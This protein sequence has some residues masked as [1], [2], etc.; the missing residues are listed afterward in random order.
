MT[1]SKLF[2]TGDHDTWVT[3]TD[4]CI[5]VKSSKV[6]QF[7]WHPHFKYCLA[8]YL[9]LKIESC[10][11]KEKFL[12][13]S[14]VYWSNLG[15]VPSHNNYQVQSPEWSWHHT[16]SC[17]VHSV[18]VAPEILS[19]WSA[20]S[21][22]FVHVRKKKNQCWEESVMAFELQNGTKYILINTRK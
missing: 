15:F 8:S 1:V 5:Q 9:E 21:D 19:Y 18:M 4:T 22:I 6:T 14:L 7:S 11:S 2:F 12:G 16:A 20:T 17:V 3:H 10:I 13:F